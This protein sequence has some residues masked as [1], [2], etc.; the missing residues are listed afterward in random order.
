[1][2]FS[3][4][5]LCAAMLPAAAANARECGAKTCSQARNGCLF[6][7]CGGTG[8]QRCGR[9]CHEKFQICLASGEWRGALCH[10]T[11]LG[12]R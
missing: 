8:K 11:R 6:M 2:F 3:A 12:R 1:L 5:M 7:H 9:Q 10:M 4:L